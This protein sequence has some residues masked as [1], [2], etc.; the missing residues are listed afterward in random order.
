MKK[1]AIEIIDQFTDNGTLQHGQSQFLGTATKLGDFT[2]DAETPYGRVKSP[3][4]VKVTGVL[5]GITTVTA[6][7]VVHEGNHYYPAKISVNGAN[8]YYNE[9]DYGGMKIETTDKVGQIIVIYEIE[10]PK[11]LNIIQWNIREH[12]PY[13]YTEITSNKG[14]VE[15]VDYG[16]TT[17]SFYEDNLPLTLKVVDP[18]GF[19]GWAMMDPSTT[20]PS[21]KYITTE[22]QLVITKE[23]W[24]NLQTIAE[25][26]FAV[27]DKKID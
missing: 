9:N 22:Q 25:N 27:F 2:W 11:L 17:L 5:N 6:D 23:I 15:V 8:E 16:I 18:E 12:S 7:P 13:P 1:S 10:E 14:Q 21:G 4:F 26:L 19:L 3:E 24:S 20:E